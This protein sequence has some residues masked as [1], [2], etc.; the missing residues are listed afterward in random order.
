VFNPVTYELQ[1]SKPMKEQDLHAKQK[2][3]LKKTNGTSG[4]HQ[5]LKLSKKDERRS[6]NKTDVANEERTRDISKGRP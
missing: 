2:D 6:R 4:E 1:N 5:D 3:E